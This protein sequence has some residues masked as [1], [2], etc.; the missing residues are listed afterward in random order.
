MTAFELWVDDGDHDRVAT[1]LPGQGY[2]AQGPLLHYAATVLRDAG[3][4]IR[5]LVWDGECRGRSEAREV[6]GHVVRDGVTSLPG[7]RHLVV[8]KS[9]GTLAMPV[10]ARMGVPGVWLTPLIS[11]HGTLDVR[12][13]TLGLGV[14]QVPALLVGG[15][16][17]ALWDTHVAKASGVRVLEVEGANHSMEVR[18]DWRRSLEVLDQ[19]TAAVADLVAEVEARET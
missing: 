14:H 6:Y 13:A 1:I 12:E 11:E 4:T 19:V 7:S 2:T 15:T 16:A 17:D 18:G 8:G 5:T 3:W 10:A 9:L